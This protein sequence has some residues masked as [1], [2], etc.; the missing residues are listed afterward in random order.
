MTGQA[1][2]DARARL[3]VGGRDVSDVLLADTYWRRLRGMLG[4]R[5]LP[6]ALLLHPGGSVHGMGMTRS[7]DVA[8]LVP[9]DRPDRGRVPV[10]APMRVAKLAVLR[11][12]A[13]VTGVR[14]AC[15]TLEAP[16]GGFAGWGLSVGDEV[17]VVRAAAGGTAQL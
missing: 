11:P 15:A 14:G 17:Q 10:D 5:T 9:R 4:R 7:L 12:F 8:V 3:L 2:R 16:V 1:G 6:P 13:L